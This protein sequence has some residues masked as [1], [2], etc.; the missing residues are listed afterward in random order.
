MS[1]WHDS[2]METLIYE[3]FPVVHLASNTFVDVPIILQDE[4]SVD[5]SCARR[6]GGI[7]D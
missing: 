2:F 6:P 7:H 1:L 4:R 3:E 5:S